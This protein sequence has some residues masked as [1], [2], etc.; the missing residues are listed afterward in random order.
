M[1]RPS[2]VADA[3][4]NTG[5]HDVSPPSTRLQPA[6]GATAW[7]WTG[8]DASAASNR[9]CASGKSTLTSIAPAATAQ[10][11]DARTLLAATALRA[12]DCGAAVVGCKEAADR[13]A[14]PPACAPGGS[15]SRQR[16]PIQNISVITMPKNNQP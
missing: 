14:P 9:D 5:R 11:R 13:A 4:P 8:A 2:N 16:P 7:S 6:A 10:K 1:K 12:A 3:P 15:S